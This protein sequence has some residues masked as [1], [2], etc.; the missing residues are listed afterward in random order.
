MTKISKSF[1]VLDIHSL[2]LG[3]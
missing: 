2:Q 1:R 3:K